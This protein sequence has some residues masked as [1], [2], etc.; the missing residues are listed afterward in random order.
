M[1][2]FAAARF[3]LLMVGIGALA[4][5]T[6]DPRV[7]GG[8]SS[9]PAPSSATVAPT[10][11]VGNCHVTLPEPVP[12]SEPWRAEL[13]GSGA[14]YGNGQLWVG[15]LTESGVIQFEAAQSGWKLGWWR[16]VPGSLTITGRRLDEP[17][18]SLRSS[19][20]D[21]YG[22][23]GFQSSGVYFPTPGCWEVTGTVGSATLTFVMF[24]NA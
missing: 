6:A 17:A 16:S 10:Q 4:A 8:L 15:G 5:C 1:R 11:M 3:A 7:P 19:V 12:S 9:T 18:P 14:A 24:V 23:R 20:P 13:F 2:M 22:D 21:G